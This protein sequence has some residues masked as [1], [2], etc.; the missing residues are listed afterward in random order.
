MGFLELLDDSF[1]GD[2]PTFFKRTTQ[3]HILHTLPTLGCRRKGHRYWAGPPELSLTE[4]VGYFETRN[5]AVERRMK[6]QNNNFT[7]PSVF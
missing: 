3:N 1:C 7:L 2:V 5:K 4:C 6:E